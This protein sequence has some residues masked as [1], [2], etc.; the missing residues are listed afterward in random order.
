MHKKPQYMN[1][2]LN[3]EKR[4]EYLVQLQE[5]QVASKTILHMDETNFNL[6][7]TRTRGH[8]LKRKRVVKNVFDGGGH[9]MHAITCIGA[10]G[11]VYFETRFGSNRY[12]NTNEFIRNLLRHVHLESGLTLNNVGLVLDNAP[13]HCRKSLSKLGFCCDA[14]TLRC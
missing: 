9:N 12:A 13:C 4:R 14:R 1:T 10:L 3:K 7:A 8:S 6:W 11:L 5:Y 2:P